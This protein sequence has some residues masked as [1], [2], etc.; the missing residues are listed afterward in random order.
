MDMWAQYQ[1][2]GTRD[3]QI[4]VTFDSTSAAQLHNLM[5]PDERYLFKVRFAQYAHRIQVH[6]PPHGHILHARAGKLLE[7]SSKPPSSHEIDKNAS[8]MPELLHV[9][10]PG[11]H[12]SN[13]A[14]TRRYRH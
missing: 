1:L 11:C 14:D 12:L 8:D 6:T 9:H 5:S 13:Y 3:A 10:M 7:S 4:N 2:V